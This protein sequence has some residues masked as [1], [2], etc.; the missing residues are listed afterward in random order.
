MPCAER[1]DRVQIDR[2]EGLARPGGETLE[3][4]LFAR[5]QRGSGA[6]ERKNRLF[7]VTDREKCPRAPALALAGEKIARNAVENVPL[8]GAGVL[9]LIDQ[10]VIDAGVELLQHP[11]RRRARQKLAGA[12]DEIVEIQQLPFGFERLVAVEN[13]VDQ[14]AKSLRALGR[15]HGR[16]LVAQPV[17]ARLLVG[18][19]LQEIGT[20]VGQVRC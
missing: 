5:E 1:K 3:F 4:L 8:R 9:R 17:K 14:T 2:V 12:G 15:R 6:L 10:N 19:L 11:A 18:K 20:G 7:F 13:G 16:P